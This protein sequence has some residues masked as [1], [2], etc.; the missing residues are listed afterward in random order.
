MSNY[1][2]NKEEVISNMREFLDYNTMEAFGLQ[3]DSELGEGP[4]GPSGVASNRLL[5][6]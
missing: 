2:S 1:G 6:R 3:R 4:R 5:L